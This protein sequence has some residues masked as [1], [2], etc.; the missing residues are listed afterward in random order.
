M[1]N[2]FK[3]YPLL[4][5]KNK[6][7]SLFYP[8]IPKNAKKAIS[9]VLS[10]R[11]L[12]QGPLVDKFEKIFSKQFCSNLPV[13]AVGAGTD[14][15][16]LSYILSNIKKDDE[17]ICPVFTCTAT[18][19]PLL[20]SGAKIKFADI[21]PETLNISIEHV[22]KLITKKTKA[23]VFVNYGGLICDLKK[24]NYLA[25][26]HKILLIQDAAQ[27]LGAKYNGKSI[28]SY[29]DFT[30]F[31]FQAI[32]HITSGD[33]G[34]LC[35]K[36]KKLIA[37]AGRIRWFGIDRPKKQGGT[38]ENDITEIGYKYQLTDIGACLLLESMK[39][40]N[41]I[42]RHRNLIYKTYLKNINQSNK[43]KCLIEKNNKTD[44]V[45]WLFTIITPYK[46]LIQ[47]Y[48]R[49]RNIETNQVHFRNDR[50][51][52]F[53]KFVKNKKFKNMDEL[54][55]NYLVLPMHTKMG[56]NDAINISNEINYILKNV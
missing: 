19:I 4:I 18:N 27:S 7:V 41:Q 14:A 32:K 8:H 42:K 35:I 40:F 28:A 20:Y 47:K 30:I 22:E 12:G 11:W 33:G 45:M 25:K 36:N 46:D 52:I 55:N 26:K 51:S 9:K 13:V 29:A 16:H 2:N 31:S 49:S 15:L 34:A 44:P 1:K 23:I 39:E 38:W 48:L 24:L 6:S 17:I 37:K 10:G 3:D 43:I 53:K 21:D 5:S 56:I 50:Y 54:Q